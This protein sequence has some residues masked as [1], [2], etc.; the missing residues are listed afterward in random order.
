MSVRPARY[1]LGFLVDDRD[2]PHRVT[3]R[4]LP[5]LSL[6]ETFEL[7]RLRDPRTLNRRKLY[8]LRWLAGKAL[9]YAGGRELTLDQ[10]ITLRRLRQASYV[11]DSRRYADALA[12][13]ERVAASRPPDPPIPIAVSFGA[14]VSSALHLRRVRPPRTAVAAVP[15]VRPRG[16]RRRSTASRSSRNRSPG[17]EPDEPEPPRGPRTGARPAW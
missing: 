9:A 17:R 16:R 7:D 1:G 3:D 2:A 13:R 5:G 4:P 8:E 12:R 11:E 15:R 14:A 6:S 10:R